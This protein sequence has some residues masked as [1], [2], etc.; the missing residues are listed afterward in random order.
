MIH[1]ATSKPI[2]HRHIEY[3]IKCRLSL[4]FT[5]A[6]SLNV[7]QKRVSF[8]PTLYLRQYTGVFNTSGES[9]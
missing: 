7:P 4:V 2:S 5:I 1:K 6:A 8:A 3:F 9:H